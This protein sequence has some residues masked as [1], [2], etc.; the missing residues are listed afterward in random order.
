MAATEA[1]SGMAAACLLTKWYSFQLESTL[2][3]AGFEDCMDEL[4]FVN[5]MAPTDEVA[6]HSFGLVDRYWA[7]QHVSVWRQCAVGTRPTLIFQDDVTFNSSTVHATTDALVAAANAAGYGVDSASATILVLD[8][9]AAGESGATQP[10]ATAP[11][12]AALMPAESTTQVSAYVLWPAAAKAL[13]ASLPID[14][15]VSAFLGKKIAERELVAFS[16]SPPLTAPAPK[17]QQAA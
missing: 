3:A 16:C 17:S 15:P 6:A 2:E 14:A 11:N 1:V 7:A 12:G 9:A 8:A 4:R 10:L 13:L 5:E